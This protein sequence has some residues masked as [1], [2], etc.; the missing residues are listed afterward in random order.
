MRNGPRLTKFAAVFIT[1]IEA[2]SLIAD[3]QS[4]S[5]PNNSAKASDS[6]TIGAF[7][8]S[9]GAQSMRT[10][11]QSTKYEWQRRATRSTACVETL[12]TPLA[13]QTSTS[14]CKLRSRTTHLT[15]QDEPSEIR[16]SG[17]PGKKPIPPQTP[18]KNG[19]PDRGRPLPIRRRTRLR[20]TIQRRFP[21]TRAAIRRRVA[22][23]LRTRK[24]CPKHRQPNLQ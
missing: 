14:Q 16:S 18:R 8:E 15:Q 4:P 5:P 3:G 2:L 9:T 21:A 10:A 13:T 22:T 19:A 11:T 24:K 6:M 7:G 17:W 23:R 20:P 1:I 12:G